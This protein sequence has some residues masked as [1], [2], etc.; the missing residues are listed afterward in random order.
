MGEDPSQRRQASKQKRETKLAVEIGTVRQNSYSNYSEGQERSARLNR[1]GELVV[2]DFF[3]QCVLDGRTFHL[4]I[5]TEDA[6]V[7]T[8][9]ALDDTLGDIL[10][11]NPVGHTAMPFSASV[12]I[13][14]VTTAT[15]IS[16]MIEVDRALN[17]YSSGGTAYVPENLRTDR[18]RVAVGGAFY[19]GA[20]DV[21]LAAKT[22]VPGSIELW[23]HNFGNDALATQLMSEILNQRFSL[24]DNPFAVVVGTGSLILEVGAATADATHYGMLDVIQIPTESVT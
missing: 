3:S 16:A 15:L 14:D 4:Q 10:W 6:P 2:I 13:V 20:P 18:P 1:R 11:D 8:T 9:G 19:V 5:G 24:R 23:R 17:R 7:N 22:A 21:T 12:N